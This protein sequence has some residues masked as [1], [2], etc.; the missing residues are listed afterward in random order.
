MAFIIYNKQRQNIAERLPQMNSSKP[1]ISFH[2][3][4]SLQQVAEN[5]FEKRHTELHRIYLD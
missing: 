2:S 1:F 3:P 4:N 5:I